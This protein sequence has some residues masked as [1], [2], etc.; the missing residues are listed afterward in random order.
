M[1][2]MEGRVC[3]EWLVQRIVD[4]DGIGQ[5]RFQG[6]IF[7]V[8]DRKTLVD[9]SQEPHRN[10]RYEGAVFTDSGALA[11]VLAEIDESDLVGIERGRIIDPLKDMGHGSCF[12]DHM[13]IG[14]MV[15]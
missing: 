5:D 8:G 11:G 9:L 1:E 2:H 14:V 12:N 13:D 7:A 10:E 3:F 15:I 6:R 4:D